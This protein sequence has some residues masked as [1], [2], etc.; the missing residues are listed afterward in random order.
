[1]ESEALGFGNLKGTFWT[2]RRV[3][4]SAGLLIVAVVASLIWWSGRS[5]QDFALGTLDDTA[6]ATVS[7]FVAGR[8]DR[9]YAK[10]LHGVATLWSRSSTMI[11][12]VDKPDQETRSVY[13]ASMFRDIEV[14]EG[15]IALRDVIVF[16]QEFNLL[17]RPKEGIGASLVLS[18]DAYREQLRQRSKRD[19]RQNVGHRFSA[20]DGTPLYSM[21]APIGGFRA[22]AFMEVV[23]D[24]LDELSDVGEVLGGE[25]ALLDRSGEVVFSSGSAGGA[26]EDR[27]GEAQTGDAE[28]GQSQNAGAQNEE[29]GNAG[30]ANTGPDNEGSHNGEGRS[31]RTLAAISLSIPD[32]FGGTWADIRFT[33]DISSFAD[34]L[35]AVATQAI[36]VFLVGILTIVVLVAVLL[37]FTIFR[38]LERFAD[39]ALDLADGNAAVSIPQ[40]G[41]DEIGL[42]GQAMEKLRSAVVGVFLMKHLVENTPTPTAMVGPDG[43][44]E[45]LNSAARASLGLMSADGLRANFLNLPEH[46]AS[47]LTNPTG[48]MFSTRVDYGD[49]IFAVSSAPVR[50]ER[51][52]FLGSMLAWNDVTAAENAKRMTENLLEEAF[53]VAEAVA[54]QS[55]HLR[56]TAGDLDRQSDANIQRT[57][58]AS[59]IAHG[60]SGSRTVVASASQQLK[61]SFQEINRRADEANSISQEALRNAERGR[62]SIQSLEQAS[63]EIGSIVDLITEIAHRTR[64]LSLNATIEAQRAGEMGRGFNV[65]ANEVKSLADQTSEATNNIFQ[66]TRT[67]RGHIGEATEVMGTVREIIGTMSVIQESI[68]R[69]V[70]EQYG[71]TEEIIAT[72]ARIADGSDTIETIVEEVN[73]DAQR[74]RENAQGL[75]GASVE[76]ARS[77]EDLRDQMVRFRQHFSGSDLETAAAGD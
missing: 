38:N 53:G 37:R 32:E 65:V 59:D 9:V 8:I 20:E 24:P 23:T 49:R 26:T 69:A 30:P 21:V 25:L 16:D 66:L 35:D 11:D 70:D 40:V 63:G 52:V 29:S 54:E 72:I 62:E 46:E 7:S 22:I 75:T 3:L 13:L 55:R 28:N 64:L 4:V 74:T 19:A 41:Q 33:R 56:S 76:L 45:V 39:A 42:V 12:A 6:A 60:A 27:D 61:T 15:R 73:Q 51:G 31:R 2:L 18:N 36:T 58:Q 57:K 17:G 67:I 14:V 47:N 48:S 44:V 77:A 71:A 10:R 5:Y 50:D 43:R 1:M 34:G 68:A